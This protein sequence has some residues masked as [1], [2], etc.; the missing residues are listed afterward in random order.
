MKNNFLFIFSIL[1]SFAVRAQSTADFTN[2]HMVG[3]S[4]GTSLYSGGYVNQNQRI[5]DGK[6]HQPSFQLYYQTR[7][8]RRF[9]L[10][11][12]TSLS[13]LSS[14]D[15]RA[16]S[17]TYGQNAFNTTILEVAPIFIFDLG[18]IERL[19]NR[20]TQWYL[21]GGTGVFLAE[22][23]HHLLNTKANKA[24]GTLNFGIGMRH[25]IKDNWFLTAEAMG[26]VTSSNTLDL[27]RT[28][29]SP[30]DLYATFQIGVAYRIRGKR[31]IR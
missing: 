30:T 3:G 28:Q 6:S 1:L 12:Q 21:M 24:G 27:N 15:L 9:H 29:Q 31:F 7:L 19:N 11:Y 16:N 22:V 13:G 25:R 26:R 17:E 18:N 5:F 2:Y 14:R 23:N 8:S 4:I 20:N 10:R